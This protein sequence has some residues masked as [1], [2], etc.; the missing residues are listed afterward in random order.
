[1][2][3]PSGG[4]HDLRDVPPGIADF[5]PSANEP[6]LDIWPIAGD[7]GAESFSGDPDD[8]VPIYNSF[9]EPHVRFLTHEQFRSEFGYLPNDPAGIVS[10]DVVEDIHDLNRL[11]LSESRIEAFR[12]LAKLWNGERVGPSDVHLLADKAPSWDDVFGGLDQRQL[13]ALRPT[14]RRQDD[15]LIDAFGGY[16]WFEAEYTVPGWLKSTYIARSRADYD[17]EERTR[18]LINGREDLPNLRG[19]PHEGLTHR[20]GVGVEAVRAEYNE[21]RDVETYV[22]LGDYT[23][24]I[25]ENDPDRGEKIIGEVLTYH[26]NNELYRHTH[27]KL[28]GLGRPAVVIFDTRATAK[29]VF[30]HWHDQGIEV[31]GAPFGSALN[32]E[33]TRSKF[34]EAAADSS[35]PWVIE[36]IFTVAQLWDVVFGDSP[37]PTAWFLSSVNW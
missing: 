15:A 12:R 23:V 10:D 25:L 21:G 13:E 37:T 16:E 29:R 7:I 33:W 36:E 27:R 1:M 8:L 30:N 18:T 26:H 24:D 17:I 11:T 6:D 28:A 20:F 32:L 2:P 22:S 3:S 14:V 9:P 19:D 35:R 4:T 34:A 31:P 5:D